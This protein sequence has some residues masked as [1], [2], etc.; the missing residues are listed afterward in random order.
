[1]GKWDTLYQQL[2]AGGVDVA[3]QLAGTRWLDPFLPELGEPAGKMLDLGCGMGADMLRA[4]QL[5]YESHGLDLEARA[6]E[7]VRER[8]GFA[9]QTHDFADPLPFRDGELRL[10]LSRFAIHYLRPREA[11]RLF[12]EVRRVLAPGG[13]FLFVVNSESH[14]KLG[15]QYDYRD[16]AEVEPNVWRLPHDMDRTFLFYTP[17]LARDLAGPGWEWRHLADQPFTHW[18]GT[19]KRA[20]VGLARTPAATA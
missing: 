5:G 20:I 19:D 8:Y 4:A 16:A 17:D 7:F 18:G 1:M 3:A 9:A 10:V 14:R 2:D 15:L 6:V 13:R 11:R 12:Q